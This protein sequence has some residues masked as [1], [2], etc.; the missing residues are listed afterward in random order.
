[1]L[2]P[3]IRVSSFLCFSCVAAVFLFSLMGISPSKT[4][5]LRLRSKFRRGLR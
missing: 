1:M 5:I 2:I 3:H 4:Q